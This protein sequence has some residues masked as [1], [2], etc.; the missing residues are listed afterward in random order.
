MTDTK[1]LSGSCH[2]CG[3][4]LDTSDEHVC[5]YIG[6]GKIR[7]DRFHNQ[8]GW[9]WNAWLSSGY[10]RSGVEDTKAAA[11]SAAEEAMDRLELADMTAE[12]AAAVLVGN[13]HGPD[14]M[15]M[16]ADRAAEGLV[17]KLCVPDLMEMVADNA[18]QAISDGTAGSDI[19]PGRGDN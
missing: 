16:V 1:R 10:S 15:E 6:T 2:R 9:S 17:G 7:A 19:S 3:Y 13:L 11:L 12:K 5:Y 4:F 14:L 8:D 18:G